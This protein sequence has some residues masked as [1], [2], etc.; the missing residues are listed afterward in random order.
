MKILFDNKGSSLPFFTRKRGME[1][2]PEFENFLRLR[3]ERKGDA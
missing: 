1:K 2:C 3:K